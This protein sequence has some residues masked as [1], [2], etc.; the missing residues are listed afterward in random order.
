MVSHSMTPTAMLCNMPCYGICHT[1]QNITHGG[2][3]CNV[4]YSKW[5]LQSEVCHVWQIVSQ[6]G[7]LQYGIVYFSIA[8][9]LA[10]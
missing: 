1:T 6:N 9:Y 10:E 3:V 5:H 7:I 2:M 4:W 8:W